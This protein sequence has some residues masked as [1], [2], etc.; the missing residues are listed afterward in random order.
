MECRCHVTVQQEQRGSLTS[1]YVSK[2][3]IKLEKLHDLTGLSNEY[4]AV[5]SPSNVTLA[6]VGLDLVDLGFCV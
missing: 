5:A 1:S 3:E 4:Y 2:L 6:S